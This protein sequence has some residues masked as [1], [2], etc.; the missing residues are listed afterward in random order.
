MNAFRG[1]TRAEMSESHFN[2][3]F[4]KD[5]IVEMIKGRLDQRGID[6][7]CHTC[8]LTTAMPFLSGCQVVALQLLG[9]CKRL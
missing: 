9:C 7:K 8:E 4:Y 5:L 6:E 1:Q 3:R 2:L